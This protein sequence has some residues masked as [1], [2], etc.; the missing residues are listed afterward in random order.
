MTR[1]DAS[2]PTERRKLFADAIVA[3]RNRNSAFLT[4]E[5]E[6]LP[7]NAPDEQLPWIQF[8]EKTISMDCTDD[9]LSRLKELVGEY[10]EFRIETLESPEEVE[11][12]HVE[13]SARSDANRL[14]G[15]IDHAF[16]AVYGYEDEYT[17]WVVSI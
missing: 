7:P 3:H 4:V 14:A 1:F 9:E 2:D 15:F 10:P 11:G 8:A 17:A 12:T 5:P 16:Q 13:I 6:A